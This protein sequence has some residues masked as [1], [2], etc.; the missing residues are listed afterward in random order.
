MYY[1]V[2]QQM[3]TMK[4]RKI[5]AQE[6]ASSYSVKIDAVGSPEEWTG[7]TNLFED[8]NIYQTW[9]YDDVRCG[10]RN[11]SRM[12]L[13]K[14]DII[15][16][17]AQA[18]IRKV[19]LLNMGVAYVRWGPIWRHALSEQRE[20]VFQQA[21]R[22]LRNEYACKRGLL[23]RLYP[24]LFSDSPA[25]FKE[26]L[27]EEGYSLAAD[28]R[29]TRTFMMDL[30][31]SLDELRKGF[32]QK[33]RN[34]LNAAGRNGL[35][36]ASGPGDEFFEAFLPIFS[37]MTERKHLPVSSA[38]TEFWEIQKHLS[39]ALKL[40]TFICR[41]EGIPCAGAVFSSIG[42]TGVYILGATNSVALKN[43]ASYLVQWNALEWLKSQ[44]CKYY[45]L[46]GINPQKNPGTFNFKQG[47]CGRN[48][49]DVSFLGYFDA[50]VNPAVS[51]A[52]ACLGKSR[53]LT[54]KLRRYFAS[55]NV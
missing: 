8:M 16:A 28:K 39:E 3:A 36:V 27:S 51:I 7:L 20:E 14:D 10:P 32:D 30:T 5:I 11:V 18:R 4:N 24:L 38:F 23:V 22:A 37:A 43:K 45:D 46:N 6:L 1:S 13:K 47:L 12:V 42:K 49:R 55:T 34:C 29:P 52:K 41:A 19:P 2:F 44:G 21:I 35:E 9:E 53:S 33:W 26:I 15:V 50:Y 25:V 31:P 48:G 17:A 40:R 54:N